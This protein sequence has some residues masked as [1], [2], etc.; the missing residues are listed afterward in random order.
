MD[1]DDVGIVGIFCNYREPEKVDTLIGSLL[2]QIVLRQSD[3]SDDI[4]DLYKT[5]VTKHTHPSILEYST[6]LKAECRSLSTLFVVVDALDECVDETKHE[7]LKEL[8]NLRPKLRLIMTSRPSIM[9][10]TDYFEDAVSLEIRPSNEDIKTYLEERLQKESKLRKYIQED[11]SLHND[12]I[13]AIVDKADGM[14]VSHIRY[15]RLY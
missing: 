1:D 8:Q 9:N 6:L 14:L 12:I 15:F 7:I 5:H 13:K 3:I 4:R 11:P 10:I 2:Q